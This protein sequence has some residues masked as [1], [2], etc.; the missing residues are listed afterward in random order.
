M[1]IFYLQKS[2]KDLSQDMPYLPL[3]LPTLRSRKQ[4]SHHNL[5]I[6]TGKACY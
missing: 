2:Q 6:A 4:A 5:E 1:A 3:S